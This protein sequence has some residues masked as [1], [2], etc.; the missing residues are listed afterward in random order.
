M[1]K[2]KKEQFSFKCALGLEMPAGQPIVMDSAVMHITST[3]RMEIENCGGILDYNETG[4]T[5][6]LGRQAVRIE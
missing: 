1:G 3:G 2:R 4:I 6:K 5:L